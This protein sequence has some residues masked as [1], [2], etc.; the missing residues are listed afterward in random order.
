MRRKHILCILLIVVVLCL[1]VSTLVIAWRGMPIHLT[2]TNDRTETISFSGVGEM[3]T[4]KDVARI[5]FSFSELD[6][7]V[8]VARKVV[9]EKA[10][11]AYMELKQLGIEERDMKTTRYNIR[12]EYEYV[13]VPVLPI[14]IPLSGQQGGGYSHGGRKQERRLVGYRVS[15]SSSIRI[16]D[17][18]TVGNILDTISDLK[19]ENVSNLTFTLDDEEQKQLEEE[20]EIVA[21][22]NAREK[23]ERVAEQSGI[24]LGKIVGVRFDSPRPYYSK[25]S[26]RNVAYSETFAVEEQSAPTTPVALGEDKITATVVLTYE[27]K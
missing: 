17:I 6:K 4:T 20:A 18:D 26:L 25:S 10:E 3:T 21:I 2:T 7:D 15:H 27:L 5:S 11:M 13:T 24:T 22:T 12:P 8:S 19:P 16:R 1:A 14:P 9:S 23:A